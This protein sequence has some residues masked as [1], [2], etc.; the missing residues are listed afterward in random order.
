MAAAELQPRETYLVALGET[1]PAAGDTPSASRIYRN[2]IAKDGF[3]EV[4]EAQTLAEVFAQSVA[5]GALHSG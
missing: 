4:L 5:S 2:V 3:P 1:R